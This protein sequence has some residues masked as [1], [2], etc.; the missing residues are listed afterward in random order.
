MS[1]ATNAENL[2]L[3]HGPSGGW[4]FSTDGFSYTEIGASGSALKLQFAEDPEA[5]NLVDSY[6]RWHSL[7][8][9]AQVAGYPML[10]YCFYKVTKADWKSNESHILAGSVAALSLAKLSFYFSNRRLNQAV[11]LYNLQ[12]AQ[13]PLA[14]VS[15][16]PALINGNEL[17]FLF[18]LQF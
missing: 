1:T 6:A 8:K 11:G 13:P 15:F 12:H 3:R 4:Q 17:G 9:V 5:A 2:S 14:A 7:G 10:F 18:W 16:A